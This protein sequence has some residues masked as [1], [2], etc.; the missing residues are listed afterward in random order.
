MDIDDEKKIS[1]SSSFEIR[2]LLMNFRIILP[3]RTETVDGMLEEILREIQV[4]FAKDEKE[5]EEEIRQEERMRRE[6]F[7]GDKFSC[8]R[9][10][11][12]LFS[13][14]ACRKKSP[15]RVSSEN[16]PRSVIPSTVIICLGPIV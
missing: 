3:P 9:R 5:E 13:A 12:I 16:V 11:H 1:S 2:R 10:P 14:N 7:K 4:K 6:D 8:L 15:A